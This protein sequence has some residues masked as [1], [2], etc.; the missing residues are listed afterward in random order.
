MLVSES[1]SNNKRTDTAKIETPKETCKPENSFDAVID[2]LFSPMETKIAVTS[3]LFINRRVFR[4]MDKDA[5]KTAG[6]KEMPHMMTSCIIRKFP[7]MA[8]QSDV[9]YQHCL[10]HCQTEMPF[11]KSNN[12]EK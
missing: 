6:T 11:V 2:Y 12:A 4:L 10:A 3:E 5:L 7:R 8:A 1:P 9:I